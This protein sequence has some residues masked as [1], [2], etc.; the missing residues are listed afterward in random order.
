[1]PQEG[2]GG[3]GPMV[4]DHLGVVDVGPTFAKRTQPTDFGRTCSDS[5]ATLKMSIDFDP[6]S[7][8]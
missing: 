7:F 2:A 4:R 1:V 8:A 6:I 3:H 5:F